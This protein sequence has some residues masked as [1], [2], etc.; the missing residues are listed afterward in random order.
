MKERK[1]KKEFK[2]KWLKEDSERVKR[3]VDNAI[4]EAKEELYKTYGL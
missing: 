2:G 3:I 4:N 1:A